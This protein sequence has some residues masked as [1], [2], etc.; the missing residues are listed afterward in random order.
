MCAI[1]MDR[2]R[3]AG[4]LRRRGTDPGG[5]VMEGCTHMVDAGIRLMPASEADAL[6]GRL[7]IPADDWNYRA[8]AR[9]G[10]SPVSPMSEIE[11]E[12]GEV[13]GRLCLLEPEKRRLPDG[14][15]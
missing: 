13:V 10:T 12:T 15:V 8:V 4:G 3:R 14:H 6:V 11:D 7:N 2:V 9:Q 5:V 1:D